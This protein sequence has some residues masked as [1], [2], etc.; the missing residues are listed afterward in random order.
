MSIPLVP[1]AQYESIALAADV[2]TL[3]ELARLVVNAKDCPAVSAVKLGFSLALRHGLQATIAAVKSQATLKV[4][5]DHQKAGTDIPQMGR[6]FAKTC[7]E[8]G[9]DGVI[10]FPHAGPRT[11]EA[12]V[13]GALENQL[14][15]IVGLMMTH[16]EYLAADGGYIVDSAP[17]AIC[18]SSLRLGV[19]NFVLPG[20][21]LPVVRRFAGHLLASRDYTLWLPG[22]GNQGGTLGS[23]LEAAHPNRAVGIIGSAIY[24]ADDPR[25]A[26][27]RFAAEVT[28]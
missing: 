5:Y 15:P 21:N 26:L 14:V 7:R 1:A 10:I 17:E 18:E 3:P 28:T 27:I 9:V 20:T 11:L 25:E 16:P 6:P 8:A 2:E 19:R 22:I 13:A 12:F 4:I 24:S 23:A